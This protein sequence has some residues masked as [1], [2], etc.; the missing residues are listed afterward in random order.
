MF[1]DLI[2]IVTCQGR[3]FVNLNEIHGITDQLYAE[4]KGWA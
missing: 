1:D 3:I 4:Q 2:K